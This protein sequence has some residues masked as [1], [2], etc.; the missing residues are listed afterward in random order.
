MYGSR[1]LYKSRGQ[2]DTPN[3]RDMI[4]ANG[5]RQSTLRPTRHRLGLALG[6]RA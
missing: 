5:G 3:G 1:S 4:Y 6:V 2:N